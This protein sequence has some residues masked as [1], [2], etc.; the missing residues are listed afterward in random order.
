M[1]MSDCIEQFGH[2]DHT[3]TRRC[4]M[5]TPNHTS[6]SKASQP[7]RRCKICQQL[8]PANRDHFHPSG[9]GIGHICISCYQKELQRSYDIFK[10]RQEEKAFQAQEKT[11]EWRASF[12]DKYLSNPQDEWT[13]KTWLYQNC[14]YPE[15]WLKTLEY[16]DFR[17]AVC[18]RPQG[19][20]HFLAR[21]HW[22]PKSRGGRT[23]LDNLVPLCHGWDGCNNHKGNKDVHEWLVSVYGARKAKRIEKRVNDYFQWVKEGDFM[24]T[25]YR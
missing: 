4:K 17:C 23:S 22:I 16:F 1:H 14:D 7:L 3:S 13:F 24:I 6:K 8:F 18:G 19:L 11:K 10:K 9:G 12:P 5:A 2:A 15:G 21:D 20:W 25:P